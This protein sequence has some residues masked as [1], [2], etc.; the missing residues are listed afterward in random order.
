MCLGAHQWQS[1]ACVRV[2]LS[3]CVCVCVC[4]SVCVLVCLWVG[5]F[6]MLQMVRTLAQFSIAMEEMNEN[7]EN[8]GD[9]GGGGV[10]DRDAGGGG[11]RGVGRSRREESIDRDVDVRFKNNGNVM[12]GNSAGNIHGLFGGGSRTHAEVEFTLPTALVHIHLAPQSLIHDTSLPLCLA[13]SV[14]ELFGV[15]LEPDGQGLVFKVFC[16][17]ERK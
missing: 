5:S 10:G 12:N 2:C 9:D 16:A 13:I 6:L 7:G 15:F 11:R 3:V 17:R 8:T 4:V 1:A 14:Y